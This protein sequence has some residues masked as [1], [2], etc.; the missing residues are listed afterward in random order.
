MCRGQVGG[1][2]RCSNHDHL[3]CCG[4]TVA[5]RYRDLK[6]FQCINKGADQTARMC[7]LVCTFAGI[8]LEF[9]SDILSKQPLFCSDIWNFFRTFFQH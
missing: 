1:V 3:L 4:Q 7:R 9:T 5:P 6:A 8:Q 2:S